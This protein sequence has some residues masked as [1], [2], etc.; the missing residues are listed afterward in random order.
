[1]SSA[2]LRRVLPM[3]LAVG[4]LLPATGQAASSPPP[5]EPHA[6]QADPLGQGLVVRVDD[7]VP[8]GE[9]IRHWVEQR[10][11]EELGRRGRALSERDLIRVA[12][13]GG[14]FD[15]QISLQVRRH[16]QDLPKQP[17]P[18]VCECG[19]DEMLD[20]VGEAIGVAAEQLELAAV[21]EREA[22]RATVAAQA[23]AECKEQTQEAMTAVTQ[24]EEEPRRYRPTPLGG[25]GLV[26][27]G[28]GTGLFVGGV[29][30]ATAARD[31]EPWGRGAKAMVGIGSAMLLGG[32]T[33][34]VIDVARCERGSAKCERWGKGRAARAGWSRWA[35]RMGGGR[36]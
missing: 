6:E 15:Y 19:S 22:E 3:L 20:R 28:L 5:P 11:Y 30:L 36:G 29:S 13:R 12:V 27:L 14:P 23:E 18:L 1:M 35:A 9:S 16:G 17:E 7:A 10:G 32:L 25:I 24:A 26:G 33:M 31:S 8:E 21:A 2:P 4:M 34:L